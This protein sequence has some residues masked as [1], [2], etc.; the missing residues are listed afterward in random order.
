MIVEKSNGDI[1]ICL[2]PKDLNRAIKRELSQMATVEEIMSQMSGATIF[3]K[4]DASASYATLG[5]NR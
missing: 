2:D 5:E 3:S 1:R 4:L